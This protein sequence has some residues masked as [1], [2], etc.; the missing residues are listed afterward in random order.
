MSY[1][2]FELNE[3]GQQLDFNDLS[4]TL[5]SVKEQQLDFNVPSTTLNSMKEQQ[6]DFNVLSTALNLM[7]EQ[8]VDFNILS[9]T[10]D[11]IRSSNWILRSCQLFELDE[12][13]AIGF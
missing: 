1:Q 2:P 12:G 5:D 11:W 3:G 7:K 6:L 9:T 4:T 13:V 10:L 8:Q